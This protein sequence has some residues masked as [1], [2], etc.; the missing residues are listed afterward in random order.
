MF[1][2]VVLTFLGLMLMFLPGL[3]AKIVAIPMFGFCLPIMTL[4]WLV[5]NDATNTAQ[6][7]NLAQIYGFQ[8]GYLISAYTLLIYIAS[9]NV[10]DFI[11]RD[12]LG[13]KKKVK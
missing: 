2:I 5:I 12:L 7:V 4:P 13:R 11:G 10:F 1:L 8:L 3:L 9:V 6:Y